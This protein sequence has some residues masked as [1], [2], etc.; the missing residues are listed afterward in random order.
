MTPRTIFDLRTPPDGCRFH[1]RCPYAEDRCRREA[2]E[3]RVLEPATAMADDDDHRQAACHFPL[4]GT[5]TK[6]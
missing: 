2:P 3:L 5:G 4:T 1:P 6:A